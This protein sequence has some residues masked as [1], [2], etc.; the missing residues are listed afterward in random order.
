MQRME[1]REFF[2]VGAAGA[3]TA[4]DLSRSGFAEADITPAI[5]SEIP[6]NYFKQF[7]KT[8]HDPCKV[9][10]MLSR[11]SARAWPRPRS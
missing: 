10:A 4:Q 8:L 9:R 5:G 3:L 2:F 11:K 7:H 1:R 6:G